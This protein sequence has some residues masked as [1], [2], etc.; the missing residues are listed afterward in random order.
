VDVWAIR[1]LNEDDIEGVVSTMTTKDY[2][3]VAIIDNERFLFASKERYRMK[4]LKRELN[5]PIYVRKN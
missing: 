2:K 3:L 4:L 5:K 1:I